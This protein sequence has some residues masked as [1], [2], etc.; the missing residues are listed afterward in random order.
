MTSV[1][2]PIKFQQL[3]WPDIHFYKKQRDILYSVVDNDETFAVAG[4]ELGKDFVGGFIA[5]WAFMCHKEVR[6]VTT[7]VHD[8]H[9]RVL[10]AE[11][12]RFIRTSKYPMTVRDG[13]PLHCNHRDIRKMVN[14][15]MCEVSYLIG[16]VSEKGEGMA[17]HHAAYTLFLMDEASGID[18]LAYTQCGTWGKKA[19]IFGNPNPC[20]N[21]FR[22]A[23][24]EGDIK[25][26]DGT[27][28]H[29]KVIK[30]TAE[31]SP[32][33]QY[34]RAEIAAGKTPSNK[35]L[36]PG[37]KQYATL[38]K[39]RKLWDKVRQ[40]IG[41]DAEFYEGAEI[42]LFPPVWLNQAEDNARERSGT[43]LKRYMGC[44][45]AEGGDNTCWCVIDRLGLIALISFKTP[46]T[47][48]IT[49][50]TLALM[51]EY[52][53]E[54][55]SVLFDRGGGGKQ[56]ADNLRRQGFSVRTVA[57]GESVKPERKR[58]LTTFDR[59]KEEDEEHY[60]YKN[61]R[62]EMYG[63]AS[64][65]IDPKEETGFGMPAEIIG[66]KRPDG[67]PSL[68]EQLAVF[69]KL[70]DGE[71]RIY[72]PPK[73]KPSKTS[74]LKPEDTLIGMIG[75]SPDEADAFVMAIYAMLSKPVRR[76]AGVVSMGNV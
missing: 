33:V 65:Y 27:F 71:G 2:D 10:W 56:H 15:E 38:L 14:G 17:G 70:L 16:K 24:K 30:I 4:N 39:H 8:D 43:K 19:F 69:P 20:N 44:D 28:Y 13:G 21:F 60:I 53:V 9:L 36:I 63:L 58:G 45:P 72:L 46:D 1:I 48:V 29:R 31:D 50:K 59:R 41:L 51:R 25:S 32:N 66:Q 68:R 57:F 35:I 34:A 73:N 55:E 75:C 49:S 62:A 40:C 52:E 64:L 54:P 42:L 11:I 61:R 7:S 22:S 67:G 23:I 3:M 5:L 74:T 37:V 12:M 18:D 26:E 76:T 6:V 47:S